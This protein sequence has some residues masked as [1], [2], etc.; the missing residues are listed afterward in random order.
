MLTFVVESRLIIIIS[1]NFGN[2]ITVSLIS[3][4]TKF[5]KINTMV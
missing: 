1:H 2:E 3:I 5:T 4:K